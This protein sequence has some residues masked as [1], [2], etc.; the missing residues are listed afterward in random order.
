M[1]EN[2]SKRKSKKGLLCENLSFAAKEAFKRLRTNI[3]QRFPDGDNPGHIIGI[4]S[5]QPTEGKSTVA[6]NTAYSLAELGKRVLLVDADM[7]RS[8][9]HEKLSIEK[10]PGL[11]DLMSGS[12]DI[13]TAIKKYQNS[14]GTVGFDIIPGGTLPSNPSEILTSKR[15]HSFLK[16]LANAYDYIILDLPPVGVVTDAVSIAPQTD[17]IVYVI[18]ENNCP[19]GLLADCVN[20]LHDAKATFLGFVMN[21]ALEG[22][23]KKY[24][25]G[26]GYYGKYG[27]YYGGGYYGNYHS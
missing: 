27:S 24:G 10:N 18:R 21:G 14:G 8:S 22:S 5:S 25:Y 6:I 3:I 13:N 1:D 16:T 11:S 9:I 4:T 26:K 20:Q 19:R 12:N 7:R 17:G 23:G 15:M 2:K